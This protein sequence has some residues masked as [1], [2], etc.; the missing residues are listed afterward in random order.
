MRSLK[1]YVS[2]QPNKQIS[3]AWGG[4]VWFN[5]WLQ[6]DETN[7]SPD[8]RI[9]SRGSAV[10]RGAH[11]RREN[12]NTASQ[13]RR[14]RTLAAVG[15][16]TEAL[17][18]CGVAVA[19]AQG[20][21]VVPVQIRHTSAAF[22]LSWWKGTLNNNSSTCALTVVCMLSTVSVSTAAL[23]FPYTAMVELMRCWTPAA[24][25]IYIEDTPSS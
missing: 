10:A 15:D 5:T 24:Y 25:I 19:I 1:T 8:G 6:L 3:L 22:K 21:V 7:R 9:G 20:A 13:N 17:E 14:Q 12:V 16:G 23:V 2:Y 4:L 18:Q 11:S